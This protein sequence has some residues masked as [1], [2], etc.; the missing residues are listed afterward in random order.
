MP[1]P[2]N[3]LYF[4]GEL[5]YSFKELVWTPSTEMVASE[6]AADD[7]IAIP[8]QC[9]QELMELQSSDRVEWYQEL[10]DLVP[11]GRSKAK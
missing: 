6:L 8:D 3:E 1:V 7:K 4:K 11:V 2:R 9:Y 5:V 10:D